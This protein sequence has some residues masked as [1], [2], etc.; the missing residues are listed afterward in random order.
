MNDMN[1]FP[2]LIAVA[3]NLNITKAAQSLNM[4]KS[5]V[6][7]SILAV[8]VRLGIKLFHR[9]TRHISDTGKSI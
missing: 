5:A 4:T 2:I 3:E 6:S 1:V 9:T 8:E 7:K